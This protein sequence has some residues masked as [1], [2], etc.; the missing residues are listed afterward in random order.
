VADDASITNSLYD[1]PEDDQ[2]ASFDDFGGDGG[3][4]GD[5]A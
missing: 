2:T 5:W 4:E 3:D 1:T